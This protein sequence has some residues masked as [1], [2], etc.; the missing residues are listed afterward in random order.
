MPG[1]TLEVRVSVD[2][3]EAIFQTWAG[4]SVVIDSGEVDVLV[5]AGI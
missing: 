1:D 5:A 2:G 4:D 3:N